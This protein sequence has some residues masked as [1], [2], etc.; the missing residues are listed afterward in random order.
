MAIFARDPFADLRP[1]IDGVYGYVAYR[2][3][4]GPDAED[5]T[6]ATFERAFRYRDTYDASKGDPRGWLIG[7]ARRCIADLARPS[8][9][10]VEPADVADQTDVEAEAVRRLSLVAAMRSLDECDH[11][12]LALRYGAD[13][14]APQIG[15]LTGMKAGTVRVALKRARERLAEALDEEPSPTVGERMSVRL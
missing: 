1:L 2:I 14:S 4:H 8:I 3:G 15:R 7:I 12:L 11:E 9:V 6:S 13:L 5:V 10:D